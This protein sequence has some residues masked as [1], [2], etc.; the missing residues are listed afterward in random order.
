MGH[1]LSRFL[2]S[3]VVA[4]NYIEPS[5]TNDTRF[6]DELRVPRSNDVRVAYATDRGVMRTI[7]YRLDDWIEIPS[8]INVKLGVQSLH[9]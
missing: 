3:L 7:D 5:Q 2:Y 6:L 4:R 1:G 9:T 8:A